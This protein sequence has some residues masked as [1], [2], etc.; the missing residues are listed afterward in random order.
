VVRYIAPVLAGNVDSARSLAWA[1]SND[2][3]GVIAVILW[4][5]KIPV[6]AYR[7]F[8]EEIWVHNHREVI[9]A[10]GTRRRLRAMFRYAQFDTSG[11]PDTIQVWR[12]TWGIDIKAAASG[13][14]WT[15]DRDLA[16]W[17]AMRMSARSPLVL[18]AEVR[19]EMIACYTNDRDEKEI[20]LITPPTAV[21]DGTETEWTERYHVVQSKRQEAMRQ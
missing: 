6:P 1:L 4:Q 16:C 15:T 2:Q 7:V 5:A 13:F 9:N 11:Q 10:V 14:S 8:L 12:G 19:R 3:R 21:V 20:V 17:F 18:L